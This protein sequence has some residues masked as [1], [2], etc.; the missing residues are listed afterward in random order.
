[1]TS[2]RKTALLLL[3]FVLLASMVLVG[4]DGANDAESGS[5]SPTDPD[6]PNV[7]REITTST[8]V[9][10][11]PDNGPPDASSRTTGQTIVY[12]SA[13]RLDV[14]PREDVSLTVSISRSSKA[15]V[16]ASVEI[17]N[18]S[19]S[20]FWFSDNDLQFFMKGVR[21]EQWRPKAD[22]REVPSTPDGVR[23][24]GL[25]FIAPDFDPA[26]SGLVYVCSDPSSIGLTKTDGMVPA[27]D[28]P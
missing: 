24:F 27:V 4:C 2:V 8:A 20:P 25:I 23:I 10:S 3:G 15:E 13:P 7:T 22:P 18:R 5:A 26:L 14:K 9:I 21:L 28:T 16:M 12:Y 11:G 1:M 19:G 17:R 6:H